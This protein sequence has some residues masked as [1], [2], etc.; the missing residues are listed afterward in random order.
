MRE[1]V[2]LLL[3]LFLLSGTAPVVPFVPVFAK[4]LGYSA[5]VVG[6]IYFV[7]PV[8]GMI[9]KPLFGAIG[10]RYHKQKFLF[11]LFQFLT[12]IAFCSILL[13]PAV[14]AQSEF[15]CHEGESLL[16]FCPQEEMN[17]CT[18]NT[19]IDNP[20]NTTFQCRMKCHKNDMFSTIC[21]NWNVPGLCAMSSSTV[22]MDTQIAHNKIS[23]A[24][25]TC[26]YLLFHNATIN[27]QDTSLYCPGNRKDEAV[28]KMNCGV[29]CADDNVNELLSG[30]IG[31]QVKS[32]YQFWTF[33]SLLMIS[34]AAM[35][36]VVSVGDAIC[37]EMLG[38]KP[39]RYGHQRL[40]GSV[41][42]GSFSLIAGLLI[43]K[44]SEGRTTK[45]YA[46]GFYMM[47][48]LILLDM[49]VSSKLKHSQTKLSTNILKDV[50]QMM[51]SFRVIVFFLWCIVV[52]LG[53]AMVWNFLF[54]HLEDLAAHGGCDYG[55]HMKT[56][57]GLVMGIQCFGG[58]LPFFFIS[59]KLLKK[60]GHVH[61]M[62]LVLLGF[63][64]RFFLYSLLKNPWYVLPIEL[65]NGITF[66]VFYATMASYASI[67]APPGTEATLQV[68]S[69]LH[70][71]V[72]SSVNMSNIC[73]D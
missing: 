22:V 61:A 54:W 36:V 20:S 14:P 3:Y 6:L 1:F 4:Q 63:G 35:A 38:D 55:A 46:I 30:T 29:T 47:A 12:I 64:V 34:W 8:V 40:W 27:K 17:N 43:D 67:V 52:G 19:V 70:I 56:L 9:A 31:S 62:S 21:D 51:N 45:N 39:Q 41:G 18:L 37:F 50:G 15:H 26:L 58:E 28:F 59:G 72:I 24:D 23:L 48:G 11:L 71:I 49:V 60:I 44:F 33:F 68:M 16:K 66:G 7:L 5:S 53:T 69:I 42:W 10:D 2:L 32:T 25:D 13:I 73:R 65:L 57:Q